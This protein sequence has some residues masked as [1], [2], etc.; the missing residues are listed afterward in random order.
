MYLPA[1]SPLKKQ[2]YIYSLLARRKGTEHA[3]ALIKQMDAV[4]IAN[5]Q[6]LLDVE[7]LPRI[8]LFGHQTASTQLALWCYK[9]DWKRT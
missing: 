8:V 9:R 7:L 6:S 1:F 3:S 4:R 5:L 2:N